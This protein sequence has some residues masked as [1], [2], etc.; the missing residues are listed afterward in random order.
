MN[1]LVNYRST[2]SP[3]LHSYSMFIISSQILSCSVSSMETLQYKTWWNLAGSGFKPDP[4]ILI[5]PDT[6]PDPQNPPDIRLYLDMDPA[7][8][9]LFVL[10][11]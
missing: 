5:Q 9:T 1:N 4:G 8:P 10:S 11:H 3:Q 7:H 2:D 6:K